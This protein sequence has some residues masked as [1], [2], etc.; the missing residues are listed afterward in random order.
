MMRP[1]SLAVL[2]LAAGSLGADTWDTGAA[3]DN[4]NAT[5]NRLA[6]RSDQVHDLGFLPGPVADEDWYRLYQPAYSS[7]EVLLEALSPALIS[8]SATTDALLQ[9]VDSAGLV[10]QQSEGSDYNPLNR[11]PIRSLAVENESQFGADRLVRARSAGCATTCSAQDAY[12]ILSRETTY[13]F[14]R[15][16]NSGTQI[17]VVV[18]QNSLPR[19]VNGNLWFW[20]AGGTL[21][22]TAPV[23]LASHGTLV[24]NTATVPGASGVSG[25]ITLTHGAPY[26][27]LSGKAVALEPATGF[28]F[29]TAMVPRVD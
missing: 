22:G 9:L 11:S 2:L 24:L 21:L 16:N 25:S 5:E 7:H 12:R 28:T 3:N 6:H 20:N 10:I 23:N 4:G 26:G 13:T 14:P 29:D 17:T 8:P 15:F 19:V 18:V 27:A 1:A